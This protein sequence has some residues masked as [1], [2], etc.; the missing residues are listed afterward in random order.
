[1]AVVSYWPGLTL[2]NL[3]DSASKISRGRLMLFVWKRYMV[4]LSKLYPFYLFGFLVGNFFRHLL[5]GPMALT[6]LG[7]VG[8]LLRFARQL[9]LGR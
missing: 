2:N 8:W 9:L 7:L 6:I 5:S 4:I 3:L 1:M